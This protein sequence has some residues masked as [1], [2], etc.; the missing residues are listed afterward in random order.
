MRVSQVRLTGTPN[1]GSSRPHGALA[2]GR[3][4]QVRAS[5]G[6]GAKGHASDTCPAG[7]NMA[8]LLHTKGL[9]RAAPRLPAGRL[10]A[11]GSARV[12]ARPPSQRPAWTLRERV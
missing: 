8:L 11:A 5:D 2:F 3:R 12:C 4:R 7:A 10:S 1:S 9:F 6:E